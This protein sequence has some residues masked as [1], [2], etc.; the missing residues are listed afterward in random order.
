MYSK[1]C[2]TRTPMAKTWATLECG[3]HSADVFW[4]PSSY[5]LEGP[6]WSVSTLVPDF[7]APCSPCPHTLLCL[8]EC[9][10]LF[11]ECLFHI[12]AHS[13]NLSSSFKTQFKWHLLQEAFLQIPQVKFIL[14]PGS[15]LYCS[16]S[17]IPVIICL[18]AY[19]LHPWFPMHFLRKA[20]EERGREKYNCEWGLCQW[21]VLGTITAPGVIW[22]WGFPDAKPEP[23]QATNPAWSLQV[24]CRKF[25]GVLLGSTSGV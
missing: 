14:A 17:H 3:I 21:L 2:E 18:P 7:I 9:C 8:P 19:I 22:N 10:I 12:L 25:T 16:I 4:T 5:G 6:A 1:T 13:S 24:T 20:W 11:L 23:A 15:C